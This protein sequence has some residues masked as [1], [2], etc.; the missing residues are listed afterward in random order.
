MADHYTAGVDY[1]IISDYPPSHVP[2]GKIEVIAFF[3]Y[4]DPHGKV[5]EAELD[6][7]SQQQPTTVL[8]E[9]VPV[10]FNRNFVSQQKLYY[11]LAALGEENRLHRKVSEAIQVEGNSLFTPEAQAAWVAAQGVDRDNFL[12]A[13]NSSES[14]MKV[15]RAAQQANR[16]GIQ[17]VPSVVVQGQYRTSLATTQSIEGTI[18][19]LDFLVAKAN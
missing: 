2:E 16:Y 11:A 10:A 17:S 6:S 19:V 18:N 8:L 4:G 1:Q 13:L 14:A 12:S 5:F 9:R 3:W 15:Q 7:W